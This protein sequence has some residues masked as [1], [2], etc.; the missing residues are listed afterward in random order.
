MTTVN[1]YCTD[2][3]GW[4]RFTPC[5]SLDYTGNMLVN[6]H[7]ICANVFELHV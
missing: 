6:L 1:L 4:D 5:H 7:Y 2:N 3:K